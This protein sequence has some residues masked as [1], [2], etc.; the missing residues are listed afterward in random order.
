MTS[1]LTEPQIK[2]Y[3][4]QDWGA[5]HNRQLK[6]SIAALSEKLQRARREALA[7]DQTG[8][9]HIVVRGEGIY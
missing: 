1:E 5:R 2:A 4:K 8:G 3:E 9:L 7:K 6:E